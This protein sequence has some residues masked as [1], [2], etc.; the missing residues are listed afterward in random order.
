MDPLQNDIRVAQHI[1]VPEAQQAKASRLQLLA[2]PPVFPL[3]FHVLPAVELD[4]QSD[5]QAT[6]VDNKRTQGQ[7][8]TKLRTE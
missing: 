3:P 4:D 1:V 2:T 8:P 7:L 6:E 5:L